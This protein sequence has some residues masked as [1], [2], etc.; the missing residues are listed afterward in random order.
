MGDESE[1]D[2][3]ANKAKVSKRRLFLLL[4]HIYGT[5]DWRVFIDPTG[6]Y[7]DLGWVFAEEIE[8]VQQMIDGHWGWGSKLNAFHFCVYQRT[9]LSARLKRT[10]QMAAAGYYYEK[11]KPTRES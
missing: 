11:S 9:R 2:I 7:D 3:G 8:E 6:I 10:C 4:T 1:G 5:Q